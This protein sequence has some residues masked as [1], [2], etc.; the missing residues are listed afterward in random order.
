M[1]QPSLRNGSERYPEY[2]GVVS[3]PRELKHLST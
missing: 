2:I 3:K 1:G